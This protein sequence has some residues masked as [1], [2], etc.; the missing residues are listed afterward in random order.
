MVR[1]KGLFICYGGSGCQQ[2]D[3]GIHLAETFVFPKAQ[4]L[5]RRSITLGNHQHGKGSSA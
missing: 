5:E 1:A 2:P 3:L 4:Q